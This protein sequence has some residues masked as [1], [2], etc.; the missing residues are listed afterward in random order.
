MIKE[1]EDLIT[2]IGE[3][4]IIDF[5]GGVFVIENKNFVEGKAT[6]YKIQG[7]G[8]SLDLALENFLHSWKSSQKQFAKDKLNIDDFRWYSS[9]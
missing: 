9:H 3:G 6:K 5:V 2:T 4:I 1:I 7:T 8:L